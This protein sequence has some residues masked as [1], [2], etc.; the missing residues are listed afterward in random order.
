[1]TLSGTPAYGKT[2]AITLFVLS[3]ASASCAVIEMHKA[4]TTGRRLSGASCRPLPDSTPVPQVCFPN[5]VS[6]CVRRTMA[7]LLEQ[8]IDCDDADRAARI[9]QDA[10][11]VSPAMSP[12]MSSQRNG[13]LIVSSAPALSA[14]GSKPKSVS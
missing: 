3:C 7:N 9:I 10:L 1:M 11:G 4:G 8:A 2:L 6:Q 12:T 13:P 14:N 5:T